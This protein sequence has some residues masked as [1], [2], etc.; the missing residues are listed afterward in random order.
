MAGT[1]VPGGQREMLDH[2]LRQHGDLASR[3]IH[4]GQPFAGDAAEVGIGPKP[5]PGAAM[6]MPMLPAALGLWRDREGIVDF[7]RMRI[8]DTE[9][10]NCRQRQVGRFHRR[11]KR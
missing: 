8:V 9:G 1:V 10:L 4:R 3:H 2:V 5:R 7:G 11:G 6:W